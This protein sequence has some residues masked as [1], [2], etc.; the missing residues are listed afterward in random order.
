[1]Y[2]IDEE[3]MDKIRDLISKCSCYACN[4]KTFASIETEKDCE[5]ILKKLYSLEKEVSK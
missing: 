4:D 5:T 2:K 1:M 3:T